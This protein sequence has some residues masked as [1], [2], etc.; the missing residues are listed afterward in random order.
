[1]E[2]VKVKVRGIYSTALTKILLQVG[3]TIIEP[4]P[5]IRSR[6]GIE[7][8]Q[9]PE[10]ALI[11]DS[12]DKQGIV[13][14]GEKDS[15]GAIVATLRSAL[16]EAVFR[17][18]SQ[19]SPSLEQIEARRLSWA[20]FIKLGRESFEIEFP[21]S[22]KLAL[23]RLRAEV[24]PTLPG[25]HLL[26]VIDSPRVDAVEAGLSGVSGE[27]EGLAEALKRELIYDHYREGRAIFIHH[28]K[29]NG[30]S[31]RLGGRISGFGQGTGLTIKRQF[32]GGGRYDGLEVPIDQ[33]DW[34][35]VEVEEGSWICKRSY[36]SAQGEL[37]GEVYNINTP[38]EFYPEGLRYVDLEVDVVRWPHGRTLVIDKEELEQRLRQG[39][40]TDELAN[41]ALAV[42]G[43]LGARLQ[44]A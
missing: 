31:F 25:H 24:A 14:E 27:E 29:L 39:F 41:K 1:M 33:G 16:P 34:G 21:S 35:M 30:V 12:R 3:F 32:R 9:E 36:F 17:P 19:L 37:K 15:V 23:D 43:E 42:A 44:S 40:L 20:E 11:R 18:L 22:C 38:I 13:I 28:A 8:A 10:D 5:V 2:G 4:S 6:F 26:K 7:R